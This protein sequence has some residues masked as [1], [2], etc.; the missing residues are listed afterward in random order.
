MCPGPTRC[1]SSRRLG[2][3]RRRLHPLPPRQSPSGA[4]ALPT[5]SICYG[6]SGACQDLGHEGNAPSPA[7]IRNRRMDCRSS[8]A[9]VEDHS[10]WEKYHGISKSQLDSLT[11]AIPTVISGKPMTR[12]ELTAAI[13]AKTRDRGWVRRSHPAGVRCS[14]RLPTKVWWPRDRPV[15]AMSPSSILASG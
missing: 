2:A 10:A 3:S 6:R 13:V 14:S 1:A 15:G 12:E 9:T 4:S 11:G 8:P 7:R 5:S